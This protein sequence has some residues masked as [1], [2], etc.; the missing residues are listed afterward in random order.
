MLVAQTAAAAGPKQHSAARNAFVFVL[1]TD[2]FWFVLWQYSSASEHI[3]S[4]FAAC[5]LT[6]HT[7]EH[8]ALGCRIRLCRGI[9][10]IVCTGLQ[11]CSLSFSQLFPFL[12]YAVRFI[13][14]ADCTDNEFNC[15]DQYCIDKSLQC[16]EVNNCLTAS[17]EDTEEC[18]VSIHNLLKPVMQIQGRP[19][20]LRRVRLALFFRR[21]CDQLLSD[22][23]GMPDISLP[24]SLPYKCNNFILSFRFF[25]C[26]II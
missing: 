3:H 6:V 9:C 20:L 2:N 1:K 4:M 26:I 19:R 11:I 8:H 17:D 14:F 16:N 24:F 18:S 10:S 5:L 12:Q 22:V 7:S 13:M 25:E 15:Q 21:N 23:A